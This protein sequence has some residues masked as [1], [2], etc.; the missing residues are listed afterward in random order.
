[1]ADALSRKVSHDSECAAF[2]CV[3]PSWIEAVTA[4]YLS[5]EQS[6]SLLSKL[7][8]SPSSVQHYTLLDGIIRYKG[9][10]WIGNDKSLHDQLI[11]VMHSTALGGHSGIP[12]TLRKLKQCFTWKGMKA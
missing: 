7:S 12:V 11:Q 9:R 4:S 2:S 6:K 1:M 3:S 5:D 8:L 10:I